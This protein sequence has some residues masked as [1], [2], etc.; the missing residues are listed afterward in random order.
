MNQMASESQVEALPESRTERA[1]VTLTR[2]EKESL[3]L[4]AM[5]D[6]TDESALFRVALPAILA[7]AEEIRAKLEAA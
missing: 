4:V 7:R 1:A 2:S 3:R 5:V 6:K